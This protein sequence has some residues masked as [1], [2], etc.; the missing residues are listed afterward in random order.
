MPCLDM[1]RQSDRV[2]CGPRGARGGQPTERVDDRLRRQV[3]EKDE[4]A[5][6]LRLKDKREG[7]TFVPNVLLPVMTLF[8][9]QSGVPSSDIASD[10]DNEK[11]LRIFVAY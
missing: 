3:N 5:L 10:H 9:V 2:G 8:Y 1:V 11:N 6:I 4:V 7:L